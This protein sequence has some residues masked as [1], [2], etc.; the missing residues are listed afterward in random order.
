MLKKIFCALTFFACCHISADKKTKLLTLL[1]LYS[2]YC[3]SAKIIDVSY[4][5]EDLCKVQDRRIQSM[6]PR[7]YD[8]FIKSLESIIMTL[9]DNP[10]TPALIRLKD[11]LKKHKK[12]LLSGSL[13]S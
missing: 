6:Q 2:G 12:D 11:F 13:R 4:E 9:S 7:S 8:A 1:N 5:I 3:E 10:S